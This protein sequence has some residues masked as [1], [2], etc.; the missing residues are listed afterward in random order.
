MIRLVLFV[1]LVFFYFITYSQNTALT[2]QQCI[3]YAK[4]NHNK[5]KND[6]LEIADAEGNIKEF[7][8]IGMPK[9]TGNAELQHFIDIPT[10]I[11]QSGTFFEGDPDQGIPANPESD[12][13]VQFGVRNSVNAGVSA[14]FLLFDGSFFIGLKA[15]RVFR[16]LVAKQANIT[17]EDLAHDVAKAYLGV[18]V[19][20]KNLDIVQ[21]NID[22]LQQTTNEMR[23]TYEE[24]FIE[25][26]D[27]DRMQLSINNLKLE[28]ERVSS[29]IEISKNVLK[30]S[31][32]YPLADPLE[33][34]ET[35]EDLPTTS[36]ALTDLQNLQV[37]YENRP[38]Y[39][40]LQVNDEL[41]ELNIKRLEYQYLPVLRGF[42]SYA[43]VLQGNKL[44][45]GIW[46]PTTVIGLSLNVPIFDGFE[47]KSKIH[48][49]KIARD[50]HLITLN[51]LENAISLEVRNAKLGFTNALSVVR[52][53]EDNLAL[54]EDI[55]K[56][57]QIKY[58]EGVGTSL[59]ITQSERDLYAAQGQLIQTEYN[60]HIAQIDLKKAL[61][62]L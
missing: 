38:A 37:N 54:A 14:D 11:I 58:R 24:G 59:E 27:L 51:E 50:Q 28:E 49:A 61:G 2:M 17:K 13:P 41:N 25:K 57:A 6:I 33:I 42:A 43:Q 32:G 44:S 23:V 15:S 26:L 29:M 35:M 55:H 7:T 20:R 5:V 52:A 34:S 56:T 9:L 36:F 10:S 22:N 40:A 1:I 16:D 45:G 8:A 60:L 62:N 31:M 12:L 48:R 18:A 39:A 47:K 30:F 3:D 19:A 21:R 4:E 53:A 46:F